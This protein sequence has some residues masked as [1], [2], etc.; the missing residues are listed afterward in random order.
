MNPEQLG[1]SAIENQE[2]KKREAKQYLV[3]NSVQIGNDVKQSNTPLGLEFGYEY[4][5][6]Q[7]ATN[8][9]WCN[10]KHGGIMYAVYMTPE[11][12]KKLE[13]AG[14]VKKDYGV[15]DNNPDRFFAGAEAGAFKAMVGQVGQARQLE[16]NQDKMYLSDEAYEAKYGV[17]KGQ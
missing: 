6:G 5:E 2:D 10:F 4:S 12:A 3:E 1:G 15:V 9:G 17:P 11:I 7:Y 8:S 13:D 16:K 14:F